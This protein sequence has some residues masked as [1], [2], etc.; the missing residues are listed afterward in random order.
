MACDGRAVLYRRRR[1]VDALVR[2]IET[3]MSPGGAASRSAIRD[4]VAAGP[5][6]PKRPDGYERTQVDDF[7]RRM[8]LQLDQH[9]AAPRGRAH[10]GSPED[11]VPDL[12][13]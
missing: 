8:T 6:L 4:E 9:N 3:A 5:A 13:S 12:N 2:R 7:L 1:W 11:A 10:L